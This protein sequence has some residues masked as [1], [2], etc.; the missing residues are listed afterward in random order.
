MTLQN[1]NGLTAAG[2]TEGSANRL[3]FSAYLRFL[4]EKK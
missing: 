4:R 3:L 2:E 1:V